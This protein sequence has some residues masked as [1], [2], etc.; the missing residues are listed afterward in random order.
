MKIVGDRLSLIALDEKEDQNID[1]FGRSAFNRYYYSAFLNVREMIVAIKPEWIESGHKGIPDVLEGQLKKLINRNLKEQVRLGAMRE[2]EAQS[3]KASCYDS[4]SH[5][6]SMLKESYNI[7]VKADYFPEVKIS[8]DRGRLKLADY[9][10][11]NAA[12][13]PDRANQY[14]GVI[15]DVCRK[16]GIC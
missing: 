8:K 16:I 3:L 7:R 1:L 15:L 5:L 9:T 2:S 10:V 12:H 6:S 13:W 11:G 14:K 4:I